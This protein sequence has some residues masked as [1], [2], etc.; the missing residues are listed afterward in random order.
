MSTR[1]SFLHNALRCLGVSLDFFAAF[2]ADFLHVPVNQAHLQ[3]I[4]EEEPCR[5]R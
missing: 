2:P 3:G 4:S 5:E 1:P